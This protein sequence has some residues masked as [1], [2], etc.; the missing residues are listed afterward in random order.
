MVIKINFDKTQYPDLI[1]GLITI[2]DQKPLAVGF[3][4]KTREPVQ[5]NIKKEDG[6]DEFFSVLMGDSIKS[7]LRL[8]E[9]GSII[10]L[11]HEWF[12]AWRKTGGNKLLDE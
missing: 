2:D 12:T 3:D 6:I 8:E 10:D 11:L 1:V 7:T 5:L 4:A 9:T